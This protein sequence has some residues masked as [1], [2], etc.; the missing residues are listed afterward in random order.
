M[1]KTPSFE[2]LCHLTE[3][4]FSRFVPISELSFYLRGHYDISVYVLCIN[5]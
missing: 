2:K 4:F 3:H 1:V 5:Q